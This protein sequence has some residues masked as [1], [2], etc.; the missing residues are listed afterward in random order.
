M[1]SFGCSGFRQQRRGA[2]SGT[3]APAS[4]EMQVWLVMRVRSRFRATTRTPSGSLTP[5]GHRRCQLLAVRFGALGEVGEAALEEPLL[6][7]WLGEVEGAGV[8]GARFIVMA[9]ASQQAGAR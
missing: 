8:G 6:G 3:A 5:G 9:E 7:P 4:G 2:P 1:P